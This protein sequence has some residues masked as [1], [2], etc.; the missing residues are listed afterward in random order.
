MVIRIILLTA[1]FSMITNGKK[2]RKA[3]HDYWI[4]Q[5]ER[6][7][8]RDKTNVKKPEDSGYKVFRFGEHEIK[9]I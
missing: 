8:N 7:I 2:K 5:I 3:N 1:N 9:K 6:T 4:P